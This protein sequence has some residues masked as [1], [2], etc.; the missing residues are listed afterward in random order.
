[1]PY[2]AQKQQVACAW[3]RW[4][5]QLTLA[6]HAM[7]VAWSTR[8]FICSI[9][10]ILLLSSASAAAPTA[11]THAQPPQDTSS[12]PTVAVAVQRSTTSK[13]SYVIAH[14][15]CFGDSNNAPACEEDGLNDADN[16]VEIAAT[17]CCDAMKRAMRFLCLQVQTNTGK[18]YDSSPFL[19]A[20]HSICRG[21]GASAGDSTV[22]ASWEQ[23]CSEHVASIPNYLSGVETKDELMIPTHMLSKWDE[24]AGTVIATD[25]GTSG[26]ENDTTTHSF[27]LIGEQFVWDEM[28]GG[29]WHSST[30]SPFLIA[31]LEDSDAIPPPE[32]SPS[33]PARI[34]SSISESGGMH[35]AHSHRVVLS[36]GELIGAGASEAKGNVT[37]LLP[38][39]EGLFM[40]IDDA[41]QNDGEC[42]ITSVG[43]ECNAEVIDL[44][45]G[46]V[47]DIE[48]PSFASRQHVLAI[49]VSFQLRDLHHQ[50]HLPD[51]ALEFTSNLHLRYQ[52]P[53]LTTEMKKRHKRMVPV[54]VPSTFIGGGYAVVVKKDGQDDGENDRTIT[55]LYYSIGGGP[56]QRTAL[57]VEA[58]TG[59][60][61]D[62]IFVVTATLFASVFGSFVMIRE[63]SVVSRW[64]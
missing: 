2:A 12:T 11:I 55:S 30:S 60:D 58:A 41:L 40:D 36:M 21:L 10:L 14:A 54:Y 23:S 38:L 53:F 27:G 7:M 50:S 39:S 47:V 3:L 45:R 51:I 52:A 5:L 20:N 63:F 48:Q 42:A 6:D 29:R 56:V 37:V 18:R 26:E 19:L 35:R 44:P 25:R 49:R 34:I 61:G 59:H 8:L 16:S 22:A 13:S 46:V 15:I 28:S 62:Y 24:D 4:T 1:M 64:V 31:S 32:Q 43:G 57:I 9:S 33:I 17:A